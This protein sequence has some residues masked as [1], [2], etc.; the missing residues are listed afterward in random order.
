MD[1]WTRLKTAIALVTLVPVRIGLLATLLGTYGLALAASA[2]LGIP[3]RYKL[4]VTRRVTRWT[5]W[6][7]GFY[8]IEVE[9]DAQGLLE[10]PRVI[11]ANHISYL[12]ILYFMSTAHCPSFVMK[13]TCLKVPLVG[14]V[15]MEL[16]GLLVDREGGGP[17]ASEAIFSRVKSPRKDEKQ[18]LLVFP[19]G[20]TT[21]GTCLLQFKTGAFRPGTP[22]LPVVLEFPIDASRGDF[23]PAYES[24]HTPTHLLRMLAQWRHRLRVRYLPL[25]EPNEMEKADAALFARNVRKEMASA[26]HVPTV[27][28]TYSDKLAYHAELMP[29]Y[30]RAGPGALYL[31]VRPDILPQARNTGSL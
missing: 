12:E 9:G 4:A 24:V 15:A 27:E 17:S 22:V 23:S 20:T 7:L 21:N 6:I 26:L 1:A 18:P 11:V 3:Q 31:Y 29:H 16:G 13:K 10:R 14:Y 8:H 5:L 30:K 25:Y 28:Q 2:R 19:E